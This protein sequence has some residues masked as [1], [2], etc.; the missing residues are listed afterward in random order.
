MNED[1]WRLD[2]DQVKSAIDVL[3]R[4]DDL[5]VN[6]IPTHE[7]SGVSI[8]AFALKEIVDKYGAEVTEIAMDS[9]CKFKHNMN[10]D[11][12]ITK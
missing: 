3:S 7:E 2:P 4:A 9:T 11:V 1:A 6:I 12:V 8:I 10:V 5:D